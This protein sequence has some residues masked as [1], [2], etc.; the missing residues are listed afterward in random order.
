MSSKSSLIDDQIDSNLTA[1]LGISVLSYSEKY[2]DKKTATFYL[3]EV[4][5]HITQNVWQIE[6]RYSEFFSIH[7][8]LNKLFPRLPQ[9][10]GKTIGKLKSDEGLNKRKE[11]LELF[12]RECVKRK[13]ILQNSDF[14]TFLSLDEN[15][16]EVLGNTLTQIFDYKKF[17]F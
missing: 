3:V 16:P 13:E 6:K 17:P 12:L 9:I 4:K 10:P 11:L 1:I 14:Q 7:E 5:S 2:V 8:K 15:A